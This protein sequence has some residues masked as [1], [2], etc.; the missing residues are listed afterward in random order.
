MC[1]ALKDGFKGE[2][3]RGVTWWFECMFLVL[4]S[5]IKSVTTQGLQ[6]QLCDVKCSSSSVTES[7]SA[8]TAGMCL[9][10]QPGHGYFDH[11]RPSDT[12]WK[13][14]VPIRFSTTD[15]SISLLTV[16]CHLCRAVSNPDATAHATGWKHLEP[17]LHQSVR[18]GRDHADTQELQLQTEETPKGSYLKKKKHRNIPRVFILKTDFNTLYF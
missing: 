5:D 4:W 9:W 7:S 11:A 2:W 1:P 14:Y 18:T 12:P 10:G 8:L 17:V 6:N 16:S 13:H 15:S 3:F